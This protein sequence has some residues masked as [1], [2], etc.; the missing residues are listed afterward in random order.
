MFSIN[1]NPYITNN[2]SQR[3]SF[4]AKPNSN[5]NPN[6]P[7]KLNGLYK[8]NYYIDG[9]RVTKDEYQ[10]FQEGEDWVKD[11]FNLFNVPRNKARTINDDHFSEDKFQ[12]RTLK[13]G[14]VDPDSYKDFHYS[15]LAGIDNVIKEIKSSVE[16]PI[17]Y[18]AFYKRFNLGINRN[19][20]LFGPPGCGKT[21]IARA[22]ANECGANFFM[23]NG[24]ELQD[25]YI[26]E[27]ERKMREIFQNAEKAEPAIIFID[28]CDS[29][30]P[31]RGNSESAKHKND[32]TNQLLT[33]IDNLKKNKKNV[34]VIMAT[35]YP[36]LL[37]KAVVRKGRMDKHI[38]IP[39][40]DEKGILSILEKK[41]EKKPCDNS[42]NK[43][44]ISKKCC[45]LNASGADIEGIVYDA[46]SNAFNKAIEKNPNMTEEDIQKIYLTQKDFDFAIKNLAISKKSL[47]S[48]F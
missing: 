2:Y 42:V 23:I 17:K 33:L 38:E 31:Q 14:Q 47:K 3:I 20:L 35:N 37:D 44:D 39:F 1:F 11:I 29:L 43:S 28:E 46:C 21:T 9:L 34:F 32:Y 25:K 48:N 41:L 40:P 30:A 4:S 6:N 24:A 45:L 8:G 7:P 36:E 22:I 26:G 16:N 15:D 27:T 5:N 18:P 19:I 13:N 12:K 10:L